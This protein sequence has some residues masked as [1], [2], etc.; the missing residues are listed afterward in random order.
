MA[1]NNGV[2]PELVL[3]IGPSTT[4]PTGATSTSP[5]GSLVENTLRAVLGW[6]PRPND[7][8]GFVA[9]LNQSFT[10]SELQGHTEFTWTPHSYAIQA[11]M[12]AVTGAQASIYARAKAALDQ[13]V[14]L[15]EGLFPLRSDDDEEDVEAIRAIVI[16]KFTQ[17][18]NELGTV[19]GPRIPR[20]DDY[21]VTLLGEGK[22]TNPVAVAGLFGQLRD[23]FGL[24]RELVNT[25]DEEQNLTNYL[26]VV[27]HVIAL[28]R[29]WA[30]QKDFFNHEGRDVFLGTQLVELSRALG[31]VAESVQELYF[32]MDSV[33]L[34]AAERQTVRLQLGLTI[35]ELFSWVE[36]FASEEAPLLIREGGKDGVIALRSTANRLLGLIKKALDEASDTL[37]P[38]LQRGFH[39]PRTVTALGEV[40][41][42]MARVVKLIDQ[43][44]R[45][46]APRPQAIDPT[47]GTV[48]ETV[49]LDIF[50][51]DF[52]ATPR[53]LLE[54][55]P[56]KGQKQQLPS[57]EVFFIS[58]TKVE[59][60][61]VL[62]SNQPNIDLTGL[63]NV[64]VRNPD[65]QS[66]SLD[67]VFTIN[68]VAPRNVN[69]ESVV[70][71][72]PATKPTA[73][74]SAKTKPD[75][76]DPTSAES[77]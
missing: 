70:D 64:V 5:L 71:G 36:R 52:Q 1:N 7:P 31:V 47:T 62:S 72:L 8:K 68:Q 49:W 74:R 12:G 4:R 34:G 30:T 20:V 40:V 51:E 13:S 58:P 18:V 53:V 16:S 14:P 54:R 9:A 24:A 45:E 73:S 66:D 37:P 10:L 17:L 29:S 41:E 6:R 42:H 59:A 39:H 50:G 11:D 3:D 23:E 60:K 15:L 57:Q 44:R 32:V 21:F 38:N 61:F 46:P 65:G 48:G 28:E 26:I 27:D 25:I 63:W 75:A 22:P 35:D 67:K 55:T 2:F 77:V 19:G 43:L 76:V 33:F 56:A 69:R